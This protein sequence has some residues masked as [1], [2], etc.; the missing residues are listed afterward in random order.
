MNI[1]AALHCCWLDHAR[2]TL[3]LYYCQPAADC[4]SSVYTQGFYDRSKLF[5][6]DVDDTT[7]VAAC[8]PPGAGLPLTSHHIL[9]PVL[10]LDA[11]AF[12]VFV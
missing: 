8:A 10:P 3:D 11:P 2:L 7:L 9:L 4:C 6:K 1:A 12:L 5:W